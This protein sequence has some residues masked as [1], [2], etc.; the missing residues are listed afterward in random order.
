MSNYVDTRDGRLGNNPNFRI[1]YPSRDSYGDLFTEDKDNHYFKIIEIIEDKSYSK[2]LYCFEVNDENEDNNSHIFMLGNGLLTHNC[3]LRINQKELRRRGGGLFGSNPMTGSIGVVTINLPRLG[4]LSKTKKEFYERFDKLMDLAAQSLAKKREVIERNMERDL[5][6]YSK[7]YL[8]ETKKRY[9]SYFYNHF[10]T[11]GI[12]G[13][14]E[15]C[16]NLLNKDITTTAGLEFAKEVLL[17][18][19][20]RMLVYQET[21]KTPFNA[22]ATPAEGVCHRLAKHDSE[23][24]KNI[25]TAGTKEAPYYTNSTNIPAKS[26][27]DIF[28]DFKHQ[29]QLQSL[30]TGGCVFHI[31]AGDYVE[32]YESVKLLIKQLCNNFKVP[33]ISFTPTFSICPEHGIIPGVHETCPYCTETES[34]QPEEA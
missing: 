21:F 30:Y 15:C 9:G 14:N 20:E 5:Y 28:D 18:M 2:P 31:Y 6:P 10:N 1:D 7:Y 11:I 27:G 34:D 3:R 16:L 12:V 24:Y 23:K 19:R 4:Y 25:I 29:E 13:M 22:E 33:Y 26:L 32:D 17:H 8:S